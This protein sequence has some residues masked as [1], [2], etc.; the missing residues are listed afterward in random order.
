MGP[1]DPVVYPAGK[2]NFDDDFQDFKAQN[3]CKYINMKI[4]SL[5]FHKKTTEN[6]VLISKKK[7]DYNRVLKVSTVVLSF[8]TCF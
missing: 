8:K 1:S 2:P 3:S 4:R 7:F 6:Q 5:I